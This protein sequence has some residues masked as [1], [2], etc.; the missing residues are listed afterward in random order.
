MVASGERGGAWPWEDPVLLRV[1]GSLA[2][3]CPTPPSL[4]VSTDIDYS[5]PSQGAGQGKG[6]VA[7][8]VPW[9]TPGHIPCWEH[10]HR[11][12]QPWAW[13]EAVAKMHPLPALLATPFQPAPQTPNPGAQG[14]SPK[15]HS[16]E[17][18]T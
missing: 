5:L 10:V 11:H 14:S 1:G 4:L 2:G 18:L 9:L 17:S 12:G 16:E 15:S 7:G 6:D 3:P 8:H 13:V